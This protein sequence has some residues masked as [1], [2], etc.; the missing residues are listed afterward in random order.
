M[1]QPINRASGIGIAGIADLAHFMA[2][3]TALAETQP[4]WRVTP[5]HMYLRQMT[6]Q[7]SGGIIGAIKVQ[8]DL[9]STQMKV[10]GNKRLHQRCGLINRRHDGPSWIAL[11]HGHSAITGAN[12]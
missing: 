5:D 4:M 9:G 10:P 6:K 11:C 7:I 1:Q 8:P 2:A 12:L 3:R